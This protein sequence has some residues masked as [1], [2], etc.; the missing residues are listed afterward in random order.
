MDDNTRCPP[1]VDLSQR[2]ELRWSNLQQPI[3]IDGAAGAPH[4]MDRA[5]KEPAP[6]AFLNPHCECKKET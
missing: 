1:V 4:N 5:Y 2:T 6:S 3:T